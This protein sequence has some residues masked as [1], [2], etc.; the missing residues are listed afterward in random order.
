[1]KLIKI[2]TTTILLTVCNMPLLHSMS[3]FESIKKKFS[4][5]KAQPSTTII[6]VS[7]VGLRATLDDLADELKDNPEYKDAIR[8][9]EKSKIRSSNIRLKKYD[10]SSKNVALHVAPQGRSSR[11]LAPL[12][13]LA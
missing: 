7:P 3:C 6:R 5:N 2:I 8:N 13:P 9:F 12:T 11:H 10:K 4:C 1:M